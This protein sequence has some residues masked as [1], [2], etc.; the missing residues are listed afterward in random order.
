MPET[1]VIYLSVVEI[2]GDAVM[3]QTTMVLLFV[4]GITGE[5]FVQ[6]TLV[7]VCRRNN[8]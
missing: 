4:V 7:L 5:E 1:S 2:T 8:R 3:P 6:E